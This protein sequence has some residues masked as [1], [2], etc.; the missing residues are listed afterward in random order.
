VVI[1]L[2]PFVP[3]FLINL[4]IFLLLI[5]FTLFLSKRGLTSPAGRCDEVLTRCRRI[6]VD[7]RQ[8]A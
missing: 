8:P 7:D 3:T 4:G 1:N 2:D 6:R 5:I